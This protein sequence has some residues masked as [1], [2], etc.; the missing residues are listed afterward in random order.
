[1]EEGRVEVSNCTLANKLVLLIGE[2]T[3]VVKR[4]EN[5]RTL[6]P[7]LFNGNNY[8]KKKET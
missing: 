7:T 8:G 6:C 2:G 1:M 3:I 4:A 5:C